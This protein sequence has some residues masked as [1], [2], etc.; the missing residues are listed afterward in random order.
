MFS[1][2]VWNAI[3]FFICS[4]L[5]FG[6]TTFYSLLGFVL[7]ADFKDSWNARTRALFAD[8]TVRVLL[9]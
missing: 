2:D 4:P 8:V 3:S 6:M 9:L 5:M 1:S 7:V